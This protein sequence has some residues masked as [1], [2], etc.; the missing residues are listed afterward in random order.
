[1]SKTHTSHCTRTVFWKPLFSSS[2]E[3]SSSFRT[4]CVYTAWW[5]WF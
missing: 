2:G 4:S 1:M 5:M 3:E